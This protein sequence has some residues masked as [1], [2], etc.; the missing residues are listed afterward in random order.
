MTTTFKFEGRIY[1]LDYGLRYIDDKGES[2]GWDYGDF[3]KIQYPRKKWFVARSGDYQGEWVALGIGNGFWF[4][5]GSYGSCSG[6]DWLQGIESKE[7][8]IEFLKAMKT[9][10]KI[11][12]TWNKAKQ[13]LIKEKANGWGDL[14]EAIDEI[15]TKYEATLKNKIKKVSK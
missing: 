14:R 8:A 5:K 3:V 13:Y 15:I 2:Q 6:C 10:V 9:I 1:V 7:G 4:H 12:T 11:G